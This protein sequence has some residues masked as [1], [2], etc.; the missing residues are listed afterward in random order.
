VHWL[1]APGR[2]IWLRCGSVLFGYAITT[3]KSCCCL[4]CGMVVRRDCLV[5]SQCLGSMA[6]DKGKMALARQFSCHWN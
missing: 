6:T 2:I 4:L 1:A 3:I 5:A